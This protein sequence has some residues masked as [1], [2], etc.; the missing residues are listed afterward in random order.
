MSFL[1]NIIVVLLVALSFGAQE[2]L[3]AI[4]FAN[5]ARVLLPPVLFFSA[6]LTVSFPMMLFLA[7]FTGLVWDARHLPYKPE[8]PVAVESADLA[9][10]LPVEKQPP[11]GT[12]L[13]VG[14]S[15]F[16]FGVTGTLMQ[17]IRPLFKRGRWELPVIMVGIATLLCLLIEFLMMSFLRGS[18]EFH[19]GLWTKLVTDALLAMLVSPLLLFMLH[20]LARLVHYE[21]RTEGLVYRFYGG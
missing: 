11:T 8:K 19:P 13:P 18:F 10:E 15:M 14:Y 12:A 7:L 16:L 20:T 2:F 3:P 6:S 1:Y 5:H 21:V 4:E 9:R 17:G